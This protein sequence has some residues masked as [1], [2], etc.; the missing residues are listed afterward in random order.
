MAF[1]IIEMNSSRDLRTAISFDVHIYLLILKGIRRVLDNYDGTKLIQEY[2]L[3][4]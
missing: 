3:I 2:T 4:I 1:S